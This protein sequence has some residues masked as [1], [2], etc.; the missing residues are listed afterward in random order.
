MEAKYRNNQMIPVAEAG[1]EDSWESEEKAHKQ[2]KGAAE[3]LL[4]FS[5]LK[6]DIIIYKSTKLFLVQWTTSI[7]YRVRLI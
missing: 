2:N 4:F 3:L 5:I 1:L 7:G 6:R